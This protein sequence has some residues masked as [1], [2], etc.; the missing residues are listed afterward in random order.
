MAAPTFVSEYELTFG[1]NS[2]PKT[3]SAFDATAGDVLVDCSAEEDYTSDAVTVTNSGTAQ[4]WALTQPSLTSNVCFTQ[5]SHCEMS[6]TQNMTVTATKSTGGGSYW[7]HNCLHYTDSDGR[8]N[9]TI[10]TSRTVSIT[11]TQDDSSIVVLITDWSASDW[12]STRDWI[13]VGGVAATEMTY[14]RNSSRYTVGIARWDGVGAAGSKAVG[15]G[16]GPTSGVRLVAIEILGTAASG[17]TYDLSATGTG[18]STGSLDVSLVA[19]PLSLSA[20]GTGSSTGSVNLLLG[21]GAMSASGTG[22]TTG[23]VNLLLAPGALSASGSSTTTGSAN[24]NATL[25]LSASGASQTAGSVDVTLDVAPLALSATGSSSSTGSLAVDLQL[26]CS[27]TGTGQTAG[28]LAVSETLALS[29]TGTGQ[30]AGSLSVTIVGGSVTHALAATGTGTTSGSLVLTATLAAGATGTGTSS[31][32]AALISTLE[33]SASG[34]DASTGTAAI[35][36]RHGIAATGTG[37][38][39]GSLDVTIPFGDTH[40]V[41][42]TGT[43]TTD[44]SVAVT[45]MADLSATGEGTT[46]GSLVL[47]R[48]GQMRLMGVDGQTSGS[49]VLNLEHQLAASGE[50]QTE[51]SL[52]MR[53]STHWLTALGHSNTGGSLELSEPLFSFSMPTHEEP[54]RVDPDRMFRPLSYYRLTHAPSLVKVNG[55]WVSMRTPPP[56]LLV[57]LTAGVDYFI[58]GYDYEIDQR[59]ARDLALAGYTANPI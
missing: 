28:S 18:T 39:A 23:S 37:Q 29:S 5:M 46:A 42:A 54:I 22:T 2:N 55:S 57:G 34:T 32:S 49:L 13:T 36:V 31:G 21:P 19:G 8:G 17:T 59:T 40:F 12:G 47:I 35:T 24:L 38:T 41:S 6:T 48:T 9:T 27:S 14:F 3:T 43:G 16:S 7:G 52:A 4:T 53:I 10:S 45:L 25:A 50:G 1:S 58:G 30:S 26:S 11:T 44:G 56:E 20:T 51:G 15:L 33:V